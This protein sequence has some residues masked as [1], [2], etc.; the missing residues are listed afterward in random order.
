MSVGNDKL[1]ESLNANR[2]DIR[3][4]FTTGVSQLVTSMQNIIGQIV[5]NS[6]F[7]SDIITPTIL[8][9]ISTTLSSQLSAF[10]SSLNTNID[11][12]SQGEYSGVTSVYY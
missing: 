10:L 1:L 3:A 9:Q 12:Y 8:Q 11:F 4:V 2:N 6:A 7:L 5:S